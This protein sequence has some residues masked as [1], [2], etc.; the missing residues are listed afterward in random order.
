MSELDIRVIEIVGTFSILAIFIVLFALVQPV[1]SSITQDYQPWANVAYVLIF[2][3]F[4]AVMSFFGLKLSP[5]L[6]Q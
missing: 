5:R 4:T 3:G 1:L 6:S 2:L